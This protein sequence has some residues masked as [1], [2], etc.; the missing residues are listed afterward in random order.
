LCA[1]E[2]H[3]QEAER[4]RGALKEFRASNARL[5]TELANHE[6]TTSRFEL[7]ETRYRAR[8]IEL[9]T[10]L[11]RRQ[12]TYGSDGGGGGGGGGG[13]D[14]GGG[15]GESVGSAL[16]TSAF[17]S[18]TWAPSG[19]NLSTAGTISSAAKHKRTTTAAAASAAPRSTH[20][21]GSGAVPSGGHG[22]NGNGDGE[23]VT[24][25]TQL[26][27][28]SVAVLEALRLSHVWDPPNELDASLC[29]RV[30]PPLERVLNAQLRLSPRKYLEQQQ[31]RDNCDNFHNCHPN[32]LLLHLLLHTP[33]FVP[34]SFVMR[35]FYSRVSQLAIPTHHHR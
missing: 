11:S 32:S 4:Q 6:E 16:S 18:N 29:I 3:F 22:G 9:E 17:S 19:R 28:I 12:A 27:G 7:Q 8:V 34:P 15:G 1:G 5:R 10:Q 31:A 35:L 14:G 25:A 21:R 20:S 24:A 13:G 23:L 33:I 30:L 26:V 2:P